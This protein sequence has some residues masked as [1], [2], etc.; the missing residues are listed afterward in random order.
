MYSYLELKG[1]IVFLDIINYYLIIVEVNLELRG[2]TI[3]MKSSLPL[4]LVAPVWDL[5]L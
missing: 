2:F 3:F 4:H 5:I 1:I